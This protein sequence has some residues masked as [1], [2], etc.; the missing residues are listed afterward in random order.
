MK[1]ILDKLN[2]QVNRSS[3]RRVFLQLGFYGPSKDM[4]DWRQPAGIVLA[5]RKHVNSNARMC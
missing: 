3:P 5:S 4:L 2:E 1:R